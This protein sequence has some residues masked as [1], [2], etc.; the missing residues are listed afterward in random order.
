VSSRG[1][2][3]SKRGFIRGFGPGLVSG[4][5]ANDPTTVGSL[6]VVGAATGYGL[7]WLVVFLLPMLAVVQ[8]IAASV[9]ALSQ[10]SVQQA[11][12]RTYGRGV[13]AIAAVAIVAIGL[14]TLA[15]DV[16]AGAQALTLLVGPPFYWFV[17]PLVAAIGWI[18]ATKSY[19]R[20]ER[21]LASC[22][23]VFLCYVASAIYARPDWGAVL[24]G[25]V[26]P[27]LNFSP[28][29]LTGAIALL[30]T[31]LTSYV[32]V[33]ESIEVAERR[34]LLSE[35]PSINADA[36]LGMCVA[37]SSFLF[38]LIS[39]AATVGKH[40]LPIRNAADAAA[41]LRPL[42][43]GFDQALFGIGLLASAAIAIPVI[44]ATNG[45]VIAQTYAK[46][47]SLTLRPREAR[48]FYGGVFGSLA[49]AAALALVPIPTMALLYW[50]S[51]AAGIATPLTLALMLMVARNVG[52][53]RG[54]PIG[55]P[56]ICAGW[57][58]TAIVTLSSLA[59]AVSALRSFI[60]V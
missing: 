44:A 27:H 51:V 19:L 46:P 60:H 16:Q 1:R 2:A 21:I 11:I 34:P 52:T 10:S 37:G 15:A 4:A 12:A 3:A 59:F 7:A 5:S 14:A 53:M 45:Y 17:L 32:Y 23:L 55:R 40:H 58:V 18:L 31:T 24:H 13:A 57:I 22:T 8:A 9:A 30:G 35:L 38:V 41:A 29:F 50:V 26:V 48:L 49:V 20:I 6:A 28:L 39:T 43:G 42:A 36:A 56:L 54:R 33:W 47:A 25:I